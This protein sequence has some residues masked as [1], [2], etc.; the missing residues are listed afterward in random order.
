[1]T[2]FQPW[3]VRDPATVV[4]AVVAEHPCDGDVLVVLLDTGDSARQRVLEVAR[5]NQGRLPDEYHASDLLREQALRLVGRRAWTG[6]RWQPPRH[7][8]VTVVCRSGRVVPGPREY[9]WLR[10]WRYANHCGD[11]FDGDVY[12]VTEHGWTGCIDHRADHTPALGPPPRHLSVVEDGRRPPRTG[13]R[14]S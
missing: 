1:M 13:R 7:V 12:L 5:V 3:E 10:A 9:F 11:A 4:Q 2:S 8:L 14:A 6:D